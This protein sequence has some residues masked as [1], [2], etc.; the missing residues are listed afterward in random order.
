MSDKT[1][2]QQVEEIIHDTLTDSCSYKTCI[3]L[4]TIGGDMHKMCAKCQTDRICEAHRD[5]VEKLADKF[6]R[7]KEK[8]ANNVAYTDHDGNKRVGSKRSFRRE[9]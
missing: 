4:E 6:D 7:Y 1:F 8:N 3:L 9:L 5:E 2:K